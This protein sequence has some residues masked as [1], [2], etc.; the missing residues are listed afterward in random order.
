[1]EFEQSS[2]AYSTS[3]GAAALSATLFG[4]NKRISAACRRS[5]ADGRAPDAIISQFPHIMEQALV[6]TPQNDDSLRPEPYALH[7]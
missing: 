3:G 4:A 5:D 7:G 2:R 6:V 1:M